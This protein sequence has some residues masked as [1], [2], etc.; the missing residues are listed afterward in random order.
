MNRVAP[1]VSNQAHLNT[2][3]AMHA[4]PPCR[5][6]DS[7]TRSSTTDY[8][9]QRSPWG[10]NQPQYGTFSDTEIPKPPNAEVRHDPSAT[11]G[12]PSV[13]PGDGSYPIEVDEILPAL[14][15]RCGAKK[16]D[17][18]ACQKWPMLGTNR[19]RLHY[20]A[21]R[22]AMAKAAERIAMARDLA[23]ETLIKRIDEE[24]D[25]IDPKLLLDTVIKLT[26]KV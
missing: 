5:C 20:G 25:L 15:D 19:C 14:T 7:S 24:G 6:G 16:K 10:S 26:E 17:G 22:Q 1:T 4:P 23:L 13:H 11:H 21:S 8:P 2:C 18:T 9:A 12:Y 3:G